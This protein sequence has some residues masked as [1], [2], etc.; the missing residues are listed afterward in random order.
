MIL[1]DVNVLLYAYDQTDPRHDLAARWVEDVMSGVDEVGLALVTIL[2]F[3]RISTDPRIHEEPREAADAI[4]VIEGWLA[5]PNV[6]IVEPTGRHW[7]TFAR[8]ASI[9]SGPRACPVDARSA[10]VDQCRPVGSTTRTFGCAH[11]PS[12]QILCT[13]GFD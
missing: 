9:S 3:L 13:A 8:C 1:I 7:S 2:A 12:F 6:R 10:N 5:Q 11:H 4:A